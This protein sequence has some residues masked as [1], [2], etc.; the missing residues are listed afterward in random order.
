MSDR[1]L[2][3]SIRITAFF[4]PEM[5]ILSQELREWYRTK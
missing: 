3:D 1:E 2:E 4:I 5:G